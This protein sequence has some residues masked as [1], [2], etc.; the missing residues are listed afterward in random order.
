[1]TNEHERIAAWQDEILPRVV[2]R[3]GHIRPDAVSGEWITGSNVVAIRY[4]QLANIVNGLALWLVKE[5]GPGR[6]GPDPDVLT[7]VGPNDV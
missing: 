7:Y 6:H 3:L 5:L 1:M 2:D 4:S